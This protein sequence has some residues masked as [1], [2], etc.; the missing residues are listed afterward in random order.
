[1]AS[2]FSTRRLTLALLAALVAILAGAGS[3]F[4]APRAE[5]KEPPKPN[6]GLSRALREEQQRLKA[7]DFRLKAALETAAYVDK[8]IVNMQAKGKDTTALQAAVS[9]YR[10]GIAS[11]RAE[12]QLA[13]DGLA[14]HDGFDA[15]GKV[16]NADTARAT[17]KSAHGHM[18]QAGKLANQAAQ[19]FHTAMEAFRKSLKPEPKHP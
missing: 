14:A 17:L 16:T 18:E 1:M 19:A 11:A 13:A 5:V 6:V 15:D 9:A 2:P 12:W 8:V 7:Q 3:A 10:T 4:A